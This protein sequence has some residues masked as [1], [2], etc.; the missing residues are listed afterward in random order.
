[1]KVINQSVLAAI[2][3]INQKIS[4]AADIHL[5]QYPTRRRGLMA[6]EHTQG[7]SWTEMCEWVTQTRLMFRHMCHHHG[8]LQRIA[9]VPLRYVALCALCRS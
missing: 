3:R 6:D 2:T 7:L 5:A 4:S 8:Q 1:M 9:L